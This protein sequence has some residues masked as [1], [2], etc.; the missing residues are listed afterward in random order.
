M[1]VHFIGLFLPTILRLNGAFASSPVSGSSRI[2]PLKD[3]YITTNVSTGPPLNSRLDNDIDS[4]NI[5]SRRP[6][7]Q[8]SSDEDNRNSTNS[9]S[10]P[11]VRTL[12][13]VGGTV[14]TE[15]SRYPWFAHTVVQNGEKLCGATLIHDDVLLT[16][17]R[18]GNAFA[19]GVVLGSTALRTIRPEDILQV[20]YSVPH[21]SFV[22]GVA[23]TDDIMLVKL[24]EPVADAPTILRLGTDP[25]LPDT[26]SAVTVLGFGKTQ[27][28]STFNQT[29]P[30]S[31]DLQEKNLNIVDFALCEAKDSQYTH[32]DE[33]R[34]ICAA[35]EGK[36]C[37]LGDLGGPL[38]A[39][40]NSTNQ[41]WQY[42]VVS[43]RIGCARSDHPSVYSRVSGYT[44]WINAFLCNNS[45]H[46]PNLCT[47]TNVPTIS[48]SVVPPST[49][50]STDPTNAITNATATSTPSVSSTTPSPSRY[51]SFSPSAVSIAKHV[52]GDPTSSWI[53]SMPPSLSNGPNTNPS[54]TPGASPSSSMVQSHSP[55]HFPPSETRR[56]TNAGDT[57]NPIPVAT[58]QRVRRQR[59]R[60]T[61]QD[62]RRRS[63]QPGVSRRRKRRRRRQ[64][65][66]WKHRGGGRE[67]KYRAYNPVPFAMPW[68]EPLPPNA[69]AF[70]PASAPTQTAP[71][72]SLVAPST[73]AAPVTAPSILGISPIAPTAPISTQLAPGGAP[74]APIATMKMPTFQG[75]S[76]ATQMAPV[77]PMEP[78]VVAPAAPMAAPVAIPT[79]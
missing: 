76:I 78:P 37:F 46:P 14:M 39:V 58:T 62:R 67:R 7:P 1:K 5:F 15:A 26:G 13:I 4:D 40:D 65:L 50:P 49:N 59:R 30:V 27:E 74:V 73:Q 23:E 25:M 16:S 11:E 38:I 21:P 12:K 63:R 41:Y 32:I 3:S 36:D 47:P 34:Q 43:F 18:C 8:T 9:W 57:S 29:E 48:P 31:S 19:K 6:A 33:T 51:S 70:P 24:R 17:A 71:T 2:I 20:S 66:R 44:E 54:S 22:E 77:A 72:V 53:A 64:I 60:P 61:L 28:S 55:E 45:S 56:N 52:D 42:G 69:S 10:L 75:S 68:R 79:V 35:S